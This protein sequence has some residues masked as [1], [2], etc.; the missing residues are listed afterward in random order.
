MENKNL[1][2]LSAEQLES[3]LGGRKRVKAEEH[4]EI[5]DDNTPL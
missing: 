3:I 2:V 4:T 5:T 1:T